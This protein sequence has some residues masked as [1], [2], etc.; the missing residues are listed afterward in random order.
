MLHRRGRWATMA[1]ACDG[2]RSE[3]HAALGNAAR[4]TQIR[5]QACAGDLL[6]LQRQPDIGTKARGQL[7]P[8]VGQMK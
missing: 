4:D 8:R 7:R 6:C 3:M 5:V 1:R 2:W